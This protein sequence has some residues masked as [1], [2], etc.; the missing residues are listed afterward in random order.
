MLAIL[1]WAPPSLIDNLRIAML[2]EAV[3]VGLQ[4]YCI[5]FD[6][7]PEFYSMSKLILYSLPWEKMFLY[8][9]GTTLGGPFLHEPWLSRAKAIQSCPSLT[10]EEYVA[11]FVPFAMVSL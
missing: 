2:M 3:E 11:S 4:H 6:D 9:A 8:P 10:E 5:Y 7:T 1:F